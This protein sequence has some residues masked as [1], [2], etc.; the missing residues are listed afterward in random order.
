M[1]QNIADRLFDRGDLFGFLIRDF[2]L[3]S[4]FQSHHEFHYIVM[5]FVTGRSLESILEA[6]L[7][8]IGPGSLYTSVVPNI[9]VRGVGEALRQTRRAWRSPPRTAP[10]PRPQPPGQSCRTSS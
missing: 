4:L 1:G 2:T 8:V 7:V 3:E 5:K 10:A 9:V 6:D